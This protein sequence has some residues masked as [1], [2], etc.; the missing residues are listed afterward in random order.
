MWPH[1]GL[2][3]HPGHCHRI[4]QTQARRIQVGHMVTVTLSSYTTDT[5]S[6]DTGRP[7]GYSDVV[8]IYYRHKLAGYR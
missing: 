1:S 5:S 3:C 2:Q 7:L 6:Q 4:L 8:I